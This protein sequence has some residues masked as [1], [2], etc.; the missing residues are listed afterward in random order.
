MDKISLNEFSNKSN[1]SFNENIN[2]FKGNI[3]LGKKRKYTDQYDANNNYFQFLSSIN[4]IKNKKE[5]KLKKI[6]FKEYDNNNNNNGDKMEAIIN[7]S[8]SEIFEDEQNKSQSK[9]LTLNDIN[10]NT[11]NENNYYDENKEKINDNFDIGIEYLS[12]DNKTKYNDLISRFRNDS[13]FCINKS[14]NLFRKKKNRNN[15][16]INSLEMLHFQKVKLIQK[17]KNKNKNKIKVRIKKIKVNKIHQK[18]KSNILFKHEIYDKNVHRKIFHPYYNQKFYYNFRQKGNKEK[19]HVKKKYF[20]FNKFDHFN[21]IPPIDENK[22]IICNQCHCPGH[23]NEECLINPLDNIENYL[24]TCFKCG[25]YMHALCSFL[26]REMPIIQKEEENDI[27]IEDDNNCY[28]VIDL[29]TSQNEENYDENYFSEFIKNNEAIR[30]ENFET[31]IFCTS[32][33]GKHRNEECLLK[34]KYKIIL[35]KER[36][37][38]IKPEKIENFNFYIHNNY[39]KTK[40]KED[41]PNIKK[42]KNKDGIIIN[43]IEKNYYEEDE[44]HYNE[45]NENA[46]QTKEMNSINII[47]EDDDSYETN[48]HNHHKI[49]KIKSK[50]YNF[51]FFND[52]Y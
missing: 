48:Y 11:Y 20:K 28:I 23:I 41:L 16:E 46:Q 7:L 19:G 2:N 27:N 9:K 42:E 29:S 45:T 31:T 22:I 30:N 34:N 39:N 25:S 5:S 33:G 18:I 50:T 38:K 47:E 24:L 21:Y 43:L 37:T 1:F 4:D 40:Y 13:C 3:N 44:S 32:C 12:D 10:N 49:Y 26:N 15:R 52:K 17:K 14:Q 51:N 8:S 35:N 6:L 36:T